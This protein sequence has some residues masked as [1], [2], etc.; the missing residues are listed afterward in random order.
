MSKKNVR[1]AHRSGG[2]ECPICDREL[3]LVEHHIGGREIPNWRQAWNSAWICASCHDL[4]HLGIILI[5]GW[6]NTTTGRTL[7]FHKK[8]DE[9][10]MGEGIIP[11]QYGQGA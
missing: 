7:F 8:G 5:E 6:W 4:V 1:K 3:P 11:P 10:V 2:K 9:P